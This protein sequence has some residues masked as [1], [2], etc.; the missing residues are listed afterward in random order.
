MIK[1]NC[2]QKNNYYIKDMALTREEK[3]KKI[4]EKIKNFRLMDDDFMTK[5]FE[6]DLES[7]SIVLQ[8]IMENP[9]LKVLEAVSQSGIKNLQGRSVRLDVK[10]TDETGKIYDIEIQRVD[11]GAGAERARYNSA[12]IDANLLLSGEKTEKLPETYVIFITENDVIGAG[13]PVYHIDRTIAE[14]GKLFGDGAHIIYV[15][16]EFRGNTP[17]GDLMHDFNCSNPADM[18][19][20]VL[21]DR[22]RYFKENKKGVNQMCRAVEELILDEKEEIVIEMLKK[23]FAIEMIAEIVKLPVESVKKIAEKVTV[24]A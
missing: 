11:K 14:T 15:N 21:A 17:V 1:K 7:T 19:L 8:I 3:K 20:K 22:A 5:F 12:L 23:N 18:K 2:I 24:K 4:L 9:K 13:E 6:N 16:G 10:A